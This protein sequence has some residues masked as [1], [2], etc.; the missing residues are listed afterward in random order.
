MFHFQALIGVHLLWFQVLSLSTTEQLN[1]QWLF[2]EPGPS[3]LL[4]AHRED[5]VESI[6]LKPSLKGL[7]SFTGLI[8]FLHYFFIQCSDSLIAIWFALATVLLHTSCV[9]S[10]LMWIIKVWS[11]DVMGNRKVWKQMVC[12][13]YLIPLVSI[14]I[15]LVPIHKHF[16]KCFLEAVSCKSTSGT[17]DRP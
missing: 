9:K 4:G 5:R 15:F 1:L 3:F 11:P 6:I 17:A 14:H 7:E 16:C 13:I 2:A 12:N 8:S 10:L